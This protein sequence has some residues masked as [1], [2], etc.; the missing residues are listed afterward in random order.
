MRSNS[1]WRAL[2][3]IVVPAALAAQDPPPTPPVVTP[4]QATQAQAAAQAATGRTVS[5][6]DIS[7]AIQ[8]SGLTQAQIQ[9]RLR[10]AG[11]DPALADPFFGAAAGGAGGAGGAAGAAGGNTT[12]FAQ[13]LQRLGI[14][15]TPTDDAQVEE[16]TR[17]S[18]DRPS[19]RAG[20]VFGKD[21]FERATTVFDP[22]TSGPVDPAYRLGIGDQ[23]QLVVT[24]QVELAYALELRRDG[25]VI[26][27][28]VGQISLAGLTMDAART[29]LRTRMGRSYSGLNSGEARLDLS[30]S[31]IRS[32]AVFVIGEVEAPGAYQVNALATVFHAIARAGGPTDRGSFRNI[33]V[34]RGNRV[35]QR[36]DL[37]DYLLRGDASGDVRLEQGDQIYVPL[38]TRVVAITGQVRRP[39]IFELR[40]NEGFSDLLNFAGGLLASA[41]VERV[42]IDRILPPERR[43]PGFERVKVDVDIKGQMDSLA[44]VRLLDADIVQVFGI[45]DVRRNVV[46]VGGQVF[47]PGEFELRPGMT[48]GS[49]IGEAQGL[50]P[51]AMA[52]RVKVIRQLPLTGQSIL[53]NVDAT[54]AAGQGFLLEEFDSIEVLDSR[55]A[56]PGGQFTVSGAVNGPR[57]FPYTQGV[58]LRDAIERAGGVDESAQKVDVFRRKVGASY[59]DTTSVRFSFDIGPG[60]VR[61]ST[62][63]GFVLERDDR[64]E[65]MSSPGF[66]PQRF[67]SV[68]GQFRYPATY[69]ISENVDRISDIVTK[70]GGTLPGAYPGSFR[71]IR[72]GLDV[73]VDF[74]RAMAG[75]NSSNMWLLDGDVLVIES[76][77]NTVLVT[78]AVANP[79]LIKY[80]AGRSVQDYIELAGGPTDYGMGGRAVVKGPAGVSERVRRVAFFF[81]SSPDVVSG[82]VITVPVRPEASAS[83][84]EIW[85]RVL[86]SATALASV[87]LAYSA[88]TR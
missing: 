58:T 85:T 5:N 23:I 39:R 12:E 8:N 28:Q 38:N 62:L 14:L 44:R 75:D 18:A 61:D 19:G 1:A 35:V 40:E 88:V 63:R 51:W 65:V 3:F 24:G 84:G 71:L 60:F 43:T 82:S 42:Q 70:A 54:S 29:V 53:H 73:R 34:R 57:A 17:P 15:S 26:V 22:V 50:L 87:V 41:S 32:N 47:Q 86:Q 68:R 77:P 72:G 30:I 16:T 56:Y 48:L 31:G 79:S 81:R 27:P 80:Q 10:S 74:Q 6:A 21:V 11:Y 13:A 37:Y 67:T 2:A 9:A 55:V 20:G 36:L 66:R 45:G 7:A 4:T 59:S 64:V 33:E 46:Q 69:A 76:D 83:A 49:L 78:G 52:D 25:T